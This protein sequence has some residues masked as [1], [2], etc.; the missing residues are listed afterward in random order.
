V[1]KKTIEKILRND[2]QILLKLDVVITNQN[3]LD[4]RISKIEKALDRNNNNN[5]TIDPDDLK[6][7]EVY[8]IYL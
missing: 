1:N 7:I 8:V 2:A 5:D 6:V 4:D 3:Q